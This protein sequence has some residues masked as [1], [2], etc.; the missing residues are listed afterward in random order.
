MAWQMADADFGMWACPTKSIP[1]SAGLC[2]KSIPF[3]ESYE[4][5][6]ALIKAHGKRVDP[7]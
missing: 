6:I 5:L 4:R 1:T 3:E 7:K 2:R